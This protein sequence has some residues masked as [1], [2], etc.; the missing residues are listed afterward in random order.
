[1]TAYILRRLLATIPVMVVVAIFVFF[2]LRLAPGDPAAI[3]AGEDA[4]AAQ[5]SAVRTQLGL[6]RPIFEQFIVWLG[7]MLQGDF[8][9]S[10]FSNLP[11]SRLIVQRIE[12]TLSLMLATLAVALCLAIPLGVLAAWKARGFVDRLVMLFAV[13]GFAIP[14]FLV[15]YVLI[16]IFA[17]KLGWLPVQGYTPIR[18]GLWPWMESLILPSVALGITYMALI[19]RVTRASMLEVLAEDYIRTATSKGLTTNRVLLLHALKNASVP[20]VTVIGIGVA[21][22]ISGVVIT[23]TVFNIPG[24]GRLTVDAVLKRDYP[25]VQGLIIVFAAAKVLVNLLI[26][27]SYVFLDPRIRY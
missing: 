26:D 14:V 19:A 24:L 21:L 22:L 18:E 23:E 2:L 10:I 4:T 8:G 9:T 3:I 11:V 7:G 25:I 13:L 12:P 16:Y 17:V 20:I 5:I 15:G 6:D 1:M 27:I